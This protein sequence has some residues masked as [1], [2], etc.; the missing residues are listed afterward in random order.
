MEQ[1]R[2][3]IWAG[4]AAAAVVSVYIYLT[5]PRIDGQMKNSQWMK[6][7]FLIGLLV[8]MIT[9]AGIGGKEELLTQTF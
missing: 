7:A 3:P 9:S 1:L 2:D 6:P 8:Y 4:G 5:A